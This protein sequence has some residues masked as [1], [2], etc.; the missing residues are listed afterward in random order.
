MAG[1]MGVACMGALLNAWW[2]S[3]GTKFNKLY[4]TA[5]VQRNQ[6]PSY[7]GLYMYTTTRTAYMYYKL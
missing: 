3:G 4:V 5:A 6:G 7:I 2:Y 1:T